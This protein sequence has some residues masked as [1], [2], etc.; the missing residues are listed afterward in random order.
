MRSR[1]GC[2]VFVYAVQRNYFFQGDQVHYIALIRLCCEIPQ[3]SS[4]NKSFTLIE[5]V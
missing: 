1:F 3:F 2:S 4:Q 5:L